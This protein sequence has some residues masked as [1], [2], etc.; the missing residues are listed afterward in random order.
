MI[1]IRGGLE[2]VVGLACLDVADEGAERASW[3]SVR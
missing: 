2:Q 3:V 1:V